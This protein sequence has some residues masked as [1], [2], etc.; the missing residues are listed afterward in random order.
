MKIGAVVVGVLLVLLIAINLI[1]ST[2]WVQ[3]RVAARIKE[4]TG[5]DLTVNGSTRLLFT[6]GPRVVITDAR[7]SDPDAHTG[8]AD[9]SVAKLTLDLNLIELL[10]GQI[11][12][13]R[14]VM[15]RPVLTMR[16]GDHARWGHRGVTPKKVRFAMAATGGMPERRREL[17]LKDVRIKDGTIAIV[18]DDH[19]AGAPKR[20]AHITARLSLPTING[21]MTGKGKFDWKD[22]RVDFSF[23]VATLADLKAKR[24][25]RLLLAL[26]TRAMAARFDGT[27]TTDPEFSGQ[28]Q[29]SAKASSIPSVL[30]WMR[31][32]P[33][34]AGAIGD[35]ELASDLSWTKQEI[36]FANIR[37]ALEHASGQGQAAIS[38]QGPR[39][40]IRAAFALDHLDLNPFLAKAK[41]QKK[42]AAPEARASEPASSLESATSTQDWFEK[43]ETAVVDRA[44]AP[45]PTVPAP[46]APPNRAPATSS[47]AEPASFDADINLNIRKARVGHLDI[48]PTS[49]GLVFRDGVMN[50]TLGGMELYGG[51]ASGKLVLDVTKPTP[52]FTGNFRLEGVQARPL[53]SDAAQFSMIAGRTKLALDVSGAGENADEI[54]SSLR[55]VGSVVVTDGYIEGIDITALINGLGDGDFNFRQ[56]PDARTAFSDLGGSFTITDGIV[57]TNNLKM[58]SP[59]L[60]VTAE[61]S[62]DLVRGNLD[63]LAHPEIVKGSEGNRGAN[64]LAGLSVPVRIEG[65]LEHPRIRPQIGSLL[66]NPDGASKAVNMIGEALQKKFEGEPM[67]QAI[68][69]F[70]GNVKIRGAGRD[71]PAPKPPAQARAAPQAAEPDQGDDD[72]DDDAMD[73]ELQNILR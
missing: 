70:L 63:I 23:E 37:F 61:G 57:E 16:V 64:F 12:V 45:P 35:G 62:V 30:A 31:E 29:L 71:E 51:N 28:G 52:E 20:I 11:D 39:P 3:S 72:A 65:P 13:V 26:D 32:T 58:V 59:L 43:P 19:N 40:Q 53:L 9:L 7:I 56:G 60:K 42:K 17:G 1:I 2:D 25:A 10:S 66:A 34:V 49:L 50:A 21:P 18:R 24:P 68:G 36:K 47:H 44:V 73:A 14:V 38:L 27:V 41:N 48:G 15:L 22:R 6:P 46:A 67:G 4:Q 5:R 54:K 69:R 8:T 55:G 33:T